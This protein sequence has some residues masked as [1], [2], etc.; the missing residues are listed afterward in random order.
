[1]S[2]LITF[3]SPAGANVLM[4]AEH[5]RPLLRFAG[6]DENDP[7][8]IFTAE[9]LPTAITALQAGIAAAKQQDAPESN[10]GLPEEH[11]GFTPNLATRAWPLLDL[12]QR[13][14]KAGKPV[15]WAG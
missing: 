1:M 5:A 9:Q 6:K 4:Y 2:A 11:K 8:G 13:A 10:D 3:S 14:E 7:Q 15:T 12:M